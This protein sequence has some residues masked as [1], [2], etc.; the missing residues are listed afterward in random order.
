[1]RTASMIAERSPD[2]V[3]RQ[4]ATT[5]LLAATFSFSLRVRLRPPGRKVAAM[6]SQTWQQLLLNPVPGNPTKASGTSARLASP[7]AKSRVGCRNDF[8]GVTVSRYGHRNKIQRCNSQ[9]SVGRRRAMKSKTHAALLILI[10][11]AQL[12]VSVR[13]IAQG[14]KDPDT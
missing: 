13:L 10:L 4:V 6:T 1:M 2:W 3:C 5:S 9:T 7:L 14:Q 12:T 8:G 11:L